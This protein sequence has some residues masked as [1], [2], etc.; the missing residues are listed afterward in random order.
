MTKI[1][2][3]EVLAIARMSAIRL[4]EDEI[5]PLIAQIEQVLSYAQRVTKVATTL[6][7][8]SRKNVNVMR[9]DIIVPQHPEPILAQAPV[10]E[11][12]FFVVPLILD[13]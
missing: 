1:S 12:N 5:E 9:A 11:G 13:N 4:Q 2:R 7:E 3:T 6:E 8:A 10:R